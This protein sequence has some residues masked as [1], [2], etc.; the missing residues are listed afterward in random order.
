MKLQ[1][2]L[3]PGLAALSGP[4]L[5]GGNVSYLFSFGDSYTTTSFNASSVQPTPDNP[6]G[7]P[8]LGLGTVADGINWV[9]YLATS[10]NETLTLSYNL[11]MY[12][13]TIDNSV[14]PNEPGDLVHQVSQQFQ[15][16][17]C[18]SQ[19]PPRAWA[20]DAALF[21]I[22][23]G[24]N[25]VQ[26]S[27]LSLNPVLQITAAM[28]TYA[29]LLQTLYECGARHFLIVNV[30]PITRTPHMLADRAERRVRQ[31]TTIRMFNGLLLGMVR[32]WRSEN[33]DTTMAFYDVFAFMSDVLDDPA[34][35]GFRDARCMGEGCVWWDD[36][37]PRSQFH[38]FLAED[39]AR[40]LGL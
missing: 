11:A 3:N 25:D 4:E 36:Y 17:Y 31:L 14:I 6:M 19:T 21:A 15:R 38:R 29:R 33:P 12:G 10:F 23:I 8:A 24:I 9:G 5:L 2:L 35:Y 1:H 28:E 26:Y 39:L 30:P 27:Y 18:Q 32:R 40:V 7:N 16:Q 34:R 22:W 37:H 13:A 20:A